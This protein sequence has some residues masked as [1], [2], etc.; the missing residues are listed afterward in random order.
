MLILSRRRGIIAA[1]RRTLRTVQLSLRGR[2]QRRG[3]AACATKQP[4][5]SVP[6]IF[7]TTN[8]PIASVPSMFR[9]TSQPIASVPSIFRTTNQPIA[10]V[11]S[12][13]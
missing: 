12:A 8:Q 11:P 13:F 7:R 6:S 10:S 2:L 3:A 9:T 1:D 4:T 5:A